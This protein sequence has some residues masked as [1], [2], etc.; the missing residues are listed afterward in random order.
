MKD[1]KLIELPLAGHF[2]LSKTMSPKI[3]MKDQEMK[4]VPYVFDVESIMYSMV[5][6]RPNIAHAVSQVSRFM[7]QPDR[8]H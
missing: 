3:E 1:A 8:V 4:R 2:R 5:C 6:C 7:V